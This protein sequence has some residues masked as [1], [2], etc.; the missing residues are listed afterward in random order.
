MSS[1]SPF[2]KLSCNYGLHGICTCLALTF[3]FAGLCS[4]LFKVYSYTLKNMSCPLF[5]S[6]SQ[7]APMVHVQDQNAKARS[8]TTTTHNGKCP[9]LPISNKLMIGRVDNKNFPLLL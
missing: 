5:G 8:C 9:S 2:L 3:T 4:I 6:G 1:T 7:G